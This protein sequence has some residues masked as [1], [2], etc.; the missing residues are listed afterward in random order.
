MNSHAT[1][2]LTGGAYHAHIPITS[3]ETYITDLYKDIDETAALYL[4]HLKEVSGIVPTCKLG[5]YSCCQ[6]YI[7]IN[8]IEAHILSQYIKREFTISQINA[9]KLK[10]QNWFDW[11]NSSPGRYPGNTVKSEKHLPGDDHYCPLL[12]NGACSIYPARPIIC[13]ASFVYSPSGACNKT[14]TGYT[15]HLKVLTSIMAEIAPHTQALKTHIER[16]GIN[17]STSLMLLPHWL[18]REMNWHF[19]MSA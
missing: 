18:A 17:Y 8:N 6:S 16:T 4:K 11:E 7:L 10:T 19:V 5:C 14:K 3:I 9:L 2:E 13:R 1:K 12:L 15:P